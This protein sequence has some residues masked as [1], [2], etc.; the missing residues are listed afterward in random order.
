MGYI[1][2]V[3]DANGFST[4]GTFRAALAIAG[5]GQSFER[6]CQ[7]L[8]LT[9]AE[10]ASLRGPM[11][12]AWNA[13]RAP[14]GFDVSHFN[15]CWIRWCS[16]CMA[17]QPFIRWEWTL[18]T[19]TACV[20]HG[21]SLRDTCDA[22]GNARR[23]GVTRLER[24]ECGARLAGQPAKTAATMV[25]AI[26]RLAAGFGTVAPL[27]SGSPVAWFRA[28]V[29]LEQAAGYPSIRRSGK[30]PGLNRL[31]DAEGFVIATASLFENWPRAFDALLRNRLS[32][33]AGSTSIQRTF[34]PLYR[35]LYK[36][37]RSA[38]F[39]F[40]RRAFEEFLH[41]HWW[42]LICRRNRRLSDRTVQDHPR[43]TASQ[44]AAMEGISPSTLSHMVQSDLLSSESASFRS[45]KRTRT[46]HVDEVRVAVGAARG[47]CTLAEAA[48]SLALPKARVRQLI[49]AGAIST[50]ISRRICPT[51][52][53]WLIPAS[54]LKRFVTF[55]ATGSGCDVVTLR[56]FL[57]YERMQSIEIGCLVTEVMR[58]A[59]RAPGNA[60][61]SAPLGEVL[62][63][64][65]EARAWLAR[66]RYEAAMSIDEAGKRLGMKQQVVYALAREGL[67]MT[68]IDAKGRRRVTP[69]GL[70]R[71]EELYVSLSVLARG[72]GTSPKA[73]LRRIRAR[74]ICGP[75]IDANRQY[76]YR[77]A[78]ISIG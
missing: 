60:V 72:L 76:F 11:P 8:E 23:W 55:S 29:F 77:R 27:P 64:R 13:I 74:P 22:C 43:V 53:T 36:V 32:A 48:I 18:K 19:A 35:I 62:L 7:L 21:V 47:A 44:A 67:L 69:D 50:L 61:R 6:A 42:G 20:M 25:V 54:E 46:L 52:A 4:L 15:H 49:D 56:A 37:L 57:R 39:D 66:Q 68:D 78:E 65:A 30:V 59:L 34:D 16:Q 45:G 14:Y 9:E 1:S 71:F 75:G 63:D 26:N 12:E 2:R 58:G 40:M 38:D 17:V 10:A 24:C 3:A 70:A 31:R 73:A 41:E 5:G 51:A 28:V 33:S